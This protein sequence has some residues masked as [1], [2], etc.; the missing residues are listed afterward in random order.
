MI[1]DGKF[2]GLTP[3][4]IVCMLSCFTNIKVSD[5]VKQMFP[6]SKDKTVLKLVE[7]IRDEFL[8]WIE[9]ETN[10]CIQTGIDYNIHYDL[11]EWMEDWCE[12]E[13]EVSC[14]YFIQKLSENG[15]FLGEFVKSLLK[16]NNI[17]GELEN[18]ATIMGNIRFLSALK[19]IP[20][21][22]L[23]FVATSQSLYI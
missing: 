16:I 13:C 15:I 23:K 8:V 18:I 20:T 11:L 14:K 22:T 12:C 4:Q 9:N 7:Y 21:M 3:S 10:L 6:V 1:E 17:C 19:Q 2:E 5:S